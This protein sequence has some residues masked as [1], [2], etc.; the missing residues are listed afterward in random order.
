M[1][2]HEP[3]PELSDEV[4]QAVADGLE[5]NFGL[6][7]DL[8]PRQPVVETSAV[9]DDEIIDV[10]VTPGT[11]RIF[12]LSDQFVS[13]ALGFPA[14]P[15]PTLGALT[16]AAAA[17]MAVQQGQPPMDPRWGAGPA[18][19]FSE[20]I[21]GDQSAA[22]DTL[23]I[24]SGPSRRVQRQLD[25]QRR[26]KD[27]VGNST[28]LDRLSRHK[29]LVVAAAALAVVA[30]VGGVFIRGILPGGGGRAASASL[31]ATNYV[32]AEAKA[33]DITIGCLDIGSSA[34][35]STA[36]VKIPFTNNAGKVSYL[37]GKTATR[38][39]QTTFNDSFKIRFC[40]SPSGKGA[41]APLTQNGNTVIVNRAGFFTQIVNDPMPAKPTATQGLLVPTVP[42]D[43]PRAAVAGATG[44]SAAE[45][46][47]LN[48]F[49]VAGSP[50]NVDYQNHVAGQD[51][52][53]AVKA[54]EAAIPQLPSLED[55]AIKA[56]VTA[57]NPTAPATVVFDKSAYAPASGVYTT[58]QVYADAVGDKNFTLAGI[59]TGKPTFTKAN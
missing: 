35:K 44:M 39:P 55:A 5:K 17:F 54:I 46:A 59:N 13:T 20:L 32:A 1:T 7:A 9:R 18:P 36:D 58:Q 38:F 10:L 25:R 48:A 43:R 52:L 29:G 8:P 41:T 19:S 28:V 40:P 53:N 14:I 2:T 4:R 37:V 34:L 42:K 57:A 47:R 3:A 22:D 11:G 24:E 6:K 27:A 51:M 26:S 49:L 50:G 15:T 16:P 30:T 12:G 33:G 45:A 56:A 31:S 23:Q 21:S